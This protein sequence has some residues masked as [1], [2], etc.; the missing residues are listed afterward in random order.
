MDFQ[1][2][3]F[4]IR[5]FIFT[6]NSLKPKCKF[7]AA[8]EIKLESRGHRETYWMQRCLNVFKDLSQSIKY[9]SKGIEWFLPTQNLASNIF[10]QHKQV[11]IHKFWSNILCSSLLNFCFLT[12]EMPIFSFLNHLNQCASSRSGI[13]AVELVDETMAL[14][15]HS[16]AVSNQDL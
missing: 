14:H 9:R 6:L 7:Y 1:P 10:I 13:V 2:I 8:N 12:R 16:K 3:Q 15:R 4:T 11:L 5:L